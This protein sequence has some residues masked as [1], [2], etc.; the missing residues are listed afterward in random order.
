MNNLLA[1]ITPL[2]ITGQV[3]GWKE[4]ASDLLWHM[5]LSV[6]M[7]GTGTILSS[8]FNWRD[9]GS[10]LRNSIIGAPHGSL[11]AGNPE[12]SGYGSSMKR[13][14]ALP[15]INVSFSAQ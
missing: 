13:T 7:H 14:L 10:N 2:T 4:L 9:T 12:N 15:D 5:G 1:E 6:A 11:P 3:L 8:I